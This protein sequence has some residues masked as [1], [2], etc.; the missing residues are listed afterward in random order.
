MSELKCEFSYAGCEAKL[1]REEME[2][3][4]TDSVQ[5]HALMVTR[6]L[7]EKMEQKERRIEQLEARLEQR[8][9]Q[10]GERMETMERQLE[11]FSAEV[12]RL[13]EEQEKRKADVRQQGAGQWN[14]LAE[15]KAEGNMEQAAMEVSG[16]EP[17]AKDAC[18]Q[19][20]VQPVARDM[21]VDRQELAGQLETVEANVREEFK[22]RDSQLHHLETKVAQLEAHGH[23]LTHQLEEV[24]GRTGLPPY[25]VSLHNFHRLKTSN[26]Y[27]T[28]PP[29]YT[30]PR[31]YKFCMRVYPNGMGEGGSS[32][33]RTSVELCSMKGEDDDR[34]TWPADCTITVQLL[35]QHRDL[36]HVTV[37]RRFQWHKPST[38]YPW[39]IEWLTRQ[40]VTHKDMVWN[41]SKQT[42]YLK[43]DN[44]VFKITKIEVHV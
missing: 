44:L 1:S 27:W 24:R 32:G 11:Q 38:A 37:S 3:H 39:K 16:H 10:V 41:A 8:D 23:R 43:N 33:T 34:L 14:K 21:E 5:A 42:H 40:L 15:G 6:T 19:T 9:R 18:V 25:L 17:S 2:K 30:H 4:L 13:R 28:S 20:E 22:K 29:L 12:R 36:D 31:G 26:S 35:N 7:Q